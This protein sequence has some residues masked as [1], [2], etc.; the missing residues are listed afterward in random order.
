MFLFT[1]KNFSQIKI[2]FNQINI[3]EFSMKNT[4]REKYNF[5]LEELTQKEKFFYFIV[6]SA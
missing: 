5:S 3:Y 1:K 2:S 6:I 4:E